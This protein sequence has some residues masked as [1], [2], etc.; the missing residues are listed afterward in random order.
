M[1]VS[2]E[3]PSSAISLAENVSESHLGAIL[4]QWSPKGWQPLS[5]YRKKLDELKKVL[6]IRQRAARSILSC[7]VFP[8]FPGGETVSQ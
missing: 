1:S 6:N 4:Q 5:Y 7:V 3:D 8:V 2:H